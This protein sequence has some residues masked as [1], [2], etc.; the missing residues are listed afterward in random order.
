[1]QK[2]VPV[3]LWK[4]W[5]ADWERDNEG[6][7][8]DEFIAN[9]AAQYALNIASTIV[10]STV[11]GSHVPPLARLYGRTAVSTIHK[12]MGVLDEEDEDD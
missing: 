12:F 11:C 1:M 8:L 3:E 10:E 2:V 7:L 5:H 9:H 4:K 6:M